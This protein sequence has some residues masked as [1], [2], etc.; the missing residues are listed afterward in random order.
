MQYAPSDL[1]PRE[2]YKVLTSFVLPRPI[3]WVT[4]IGP[5]GVVN[6]APFSYF[7]VLGEDPPILVFSADARASGAAKDTVRNVLDKLAM[8]GET[9][10][11]L[12][13]PSIRPYVRSIIERFRPSTVVLSQNEIF[14][15][16]KIKTLGQI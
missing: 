4:T 6:A 1:K 15:K 3:A 8:Q 5:T 16:V 2:R 7:N 9:P 14:T 10:V 12:T 13:S 11:L